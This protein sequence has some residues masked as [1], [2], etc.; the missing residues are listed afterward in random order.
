L[1]PVVA[2]GQPDLAA[3]GAGTLHTLQVLTVT[4][5]RVAH[6][7]VFQDPAVFEIFGLPATLSTGGTGH[8][9]AGGGTHY[10]TR[11]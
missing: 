8:A 2:N 5:G 10:G 6:N 4:G 7:V 1:R 3:Y 11:E 9:D